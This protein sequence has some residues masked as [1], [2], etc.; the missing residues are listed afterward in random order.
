MKRFHRGNVVLSEETYERVEPILSWVGDHIG[1]FNLPVIGGSLADLLDVDVQ[2][3]QGVKLP[4]AIAACV[5]Y[6][7]VWIRSRIL[8]G[9]EEDVELPVYDT[10]TVEVK[11]AAKLT[12]RKGQKEQF[13]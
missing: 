8:Q 13:E 6:G 2:E 10:D 3:L 11:D 7:V 9:R 1:M 4:I 12:V 5:A